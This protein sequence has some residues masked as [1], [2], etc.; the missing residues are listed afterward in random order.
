M[1]IRP[2]MED[3]ILQT[4][5]IVKQFPGQLVLKNVSLSFKKAS[6][7]ALVGEN[8]AGK[9][10]LVNIISGAIAPTSG[11]F[12]FEGKKVGQVTPW[13]TQRMG[14]GVIHQELNLIPEMTVAENLFLGQEIKNR[15]GKIDWK[16]MNRRAGELLESFNLDFHEKSKI[17]SLSIAKQQMVEIIKVVS[18]DAKL[19][20]MDEP[21]AVLTERETTRLF[22]LVKDLKA[23]G[24]TIVYISHRLNELK[25]ICDTISVL[26]DGIHVH[27]GPMEGLTTDQIVEMMVAH[28]VSDQ[29]PYITGKMSDVA[30]KVENLRQGT[31]LSGISFE[32]YKGEILGIYGLVG[33]G[34]TELA[35]A[36]IGADKRDG[37]IL[38]LD[39]IPVQIK[40]PTD[41]INNGVA[42][43]TESRR[44]FG[45]MLDMDIKF[46]C[47][48]ASLK[49][50][51][52][53]LGRIDKR[54]ELLLVEGMMKGLS[55]KAES[56][57]KP[58]GKLSGGNQQKVLLARYLLTKPRVLIFDEP[59]RGIDVGAKVSIYQILNQLKSEGIAILMIS[60][61]LPEVMGVSDRIMVMYNGA[62][63]GIIR[64][65]EMSEEVIGYCAFG[66][67]KG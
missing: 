50:Y 26:R 52:K 16:E 8:G 34:R 39:G 35:R 59:T 46:N 25:E 23:Q 29:Y 49:Q 33:A 1:K 30:L 58:A 62:V 14:I 4:H 47:S 43:I 20:F 7:H 55:I 56:Y 45:L 27:T 57:K 10:T 5:D 32:A 21:T 38:E 6:V 63:T 9:S 64:R 2:D 44:E 31:R 41:A 12:E 15:F 40:N 19:I 48:I 67:R 60:S 54:S 22:Q 11:Y 36:M 65:E 24:R 13:D 3:Y 61:D 18:T 42:Y 37:G 53:H 51:V 17:N 28:A 66:N